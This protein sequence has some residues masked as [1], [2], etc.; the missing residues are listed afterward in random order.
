MF[1]SD[2][3]I[4][5]AID[6]RTREVTIGESLEQRAAHVMR[7]AL[8]AAAVHGHEQADVLIEIQM[9]IAVEPL[10][11]AAVTD[12]ATTVTR[13]LIEAE[14][15]AIQSRQHVERSGVH[16]LCGRRLK[17]L[18]VAEPALLKMR[19]HEAAHVGAACR[20][21]A[22]RSHTHDLVRFRLALRG[23]RV[24]VRY[25]SLELL[26]QRLTERRMLHAERLED[27]LLDIVVER[28][29]GNSRDHVPGK[30]CRVVRIGGR[31][32]GRIDALG[33]PAFQQIGKR[34]DGLAG[35]ADQ[36]LEL[37]FEARGM[38]HDVAQRDRL[39]VARRNLEIQIAIHI[40]IEIELPLLDHL[41]DGRPCE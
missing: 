35:I 14:Q 40:G 23:N 18:A 31:R 4:D 29:A 32:A 3:R 12:D 26:R 17:N 19:D 16:L 13:L 24:P 38:R 37:L 11:I 10:R 25:L 33:H 36:I 15:H 21:T 7:G 41:H 1:G 8:L 20:Q 28:H 2:L 6:G 34:C 30:C 22:R 39:P 27:A 5:A 9:Q